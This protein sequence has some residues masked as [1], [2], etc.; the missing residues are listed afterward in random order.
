MTN[1]V[2]QEETTGCGFACVAMITNS[3]Y[4]EIKALANS[5]GMFAEDEALFTTTNYVRKLLS[6]L[7]LQPGEEE[8]TFTDWD[9]LP[10]LALLATKYRIENGTPRWHWSVYTNQPPRVL[11]PAAYLEINERTDFENIDVEWY[12]PCQ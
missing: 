2:L 11:D 10:P 1:L 5:Q 6:D 9:T 3:T 8:V 7:G 12:I 4:Q